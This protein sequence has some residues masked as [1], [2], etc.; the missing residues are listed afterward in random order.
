M[1]KRQILI[2]LILQSIFI[3]TV[4]A[5][6]SEKDMKL[7]PGGEYIM[8][9]D[10][11]SDSD[12]SPAHKVAVDSFFMDIHEVTNLEYYTFCKETGHKLPEF[13]GTDKYRSSLKYSNCPVIGVSKNDARK[14]AEYAGKRLPTEAEWEYA[15][16]GGL[17]DKNYSNGDVFKSC[18]NIDSV[19]NKGDRHPYNVLSGKQNNFG[20]YGMSG[21]AR[22]WVSDIY[23]KDYYKN[24][25]TKNPKGPEN[26][27]LTVVRGGGWKSGSA[28]K[29]VFI[30][31]ALRGSWVDITI[32][33]RCVKD[34]E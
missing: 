6:N 31:N 7:I 19:F 14:Y 5:Q 1:M 20:L 15:A 4:T 24:S 9:K 33:F 12:Y 23:E 3:T 13:W 11:E 17:I 28:C 16:R 29:K 10:S 18:I 21:N 8:G 32:G 22:E 34:L 30:R 2:F 26:G 27:R 25:P